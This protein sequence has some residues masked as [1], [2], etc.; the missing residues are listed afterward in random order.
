M[1]AKFFKIACRV[2]EPTGN[3][4]RGTRHGKVGW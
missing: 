2:S 4:N 1:L 3:R